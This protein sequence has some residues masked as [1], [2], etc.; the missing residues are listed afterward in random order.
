MPNDSKHALLTCNLKFRAIILLVYYYILLLK[1]EWEDLSLRKRKAVLEAC[2]NPCKRKK[3]DSVERKNQSDALTEEEADKVEE[4][5]MRDDIS[6][7]CPGEKDFVSVKK[8]SGR[9]QKQK[10]LLLLNIHEGYEVF[11]EENDI[12]T[13][14]STFAS[15]RP[16]QV[17]PMTS[18][19]QDVCIC[20]YHENIDLI[21]SGL[22]K[23]SPGIPNCSDSLLDSV[24]C[25]HDKASC[26]DGAF[27]SVVI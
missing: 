6:R 17:T 3:L 24:V 8:Q 11:K 10:R 21:L 9:V 25:S 15:L 26:M 13:G 5:F 20:K 27:Q 22:A 4:F 1:C 23:Y 14:K 19:D 12:K 16:A 7:M 18:R 2:D